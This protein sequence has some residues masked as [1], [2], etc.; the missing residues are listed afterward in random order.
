MRF[1]I[2]SICLFVVSCATT[3]QV[4]V[5]EQPLK[6]SYLP[7]KINLDSLMPVEKNV[8]DTNLPDFESISI[9]TG[10][11]VTI[12][13]DTLKLH[14]GVLISD[15]K[16]ALL[17]YYRTG[18]GYLDKKSMLANKLYNDYYVRSFEAEK[19]YQQQIQILEKESKRSW[20]E[21]NL[22]YFG[23]VAGI[24]TAILTEFAVIKSIQ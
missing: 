11:L 14:S 4:V 8:V 5:H 23:F 20:L 15:K 22:V 2:L 24:A 16:A 3:S 9:D 17:I 10:K 7:Q 6:Y 21:K 19:T 18:Y 13:K 1:L 12:Y